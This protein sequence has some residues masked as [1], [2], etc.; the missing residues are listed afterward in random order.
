MIKDKNEDILCHCF[1][2][3]K[4]EL[5]NAINKGIKTFSEIQKETMACKGCRRCKSIIQETIQ[6]IITNHH[7]KK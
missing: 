6:N 3:S 7:E 5:I 4:S 2:V 1:E